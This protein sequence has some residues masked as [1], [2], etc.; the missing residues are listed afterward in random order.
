MVGN[1]GF[2]SVMTFGHP[3]SNRNTEAEKT[4]P[5]VLEKSFSGCSAC[6]SEIHDKS[7]I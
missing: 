3:V 4:Y 2:V 6:F 1:G 7:V 5:S